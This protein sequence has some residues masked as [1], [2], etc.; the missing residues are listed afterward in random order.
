MT[1]EVFTEIP[2]PAGRQRNLHIQWLRAAAAIMVVLFHASVY[3]VI[4]LKDNTFLNVLDGRLG[5]A[6]VS[7]FFAI[8]GYLMATA[9]K[10]Q[11]PVIFLAH[12]VVRIYP[13]FFIVAALY[14]LVEYILHQPV[15]LN[16]AAL[17]LAPVG[18]TA[19]YPLRVE[20][21]LV[22]EVT[23]YVTLFLVALCGQ[24]RRLPLVALA[25]L[26]LLAGFSILRPDQG[27]LTYPVQRILTVCENVGMAGGLLIPSLLRFRLPPWL[28]LAVGLA[29][30]PI[31]TVYTP[32]ID[33]TR[34][35]FGIGATLVVAGTIGLSVRWPDFGRNRAGVAMAA[36]GDYSYAL[37]LVHVPVIYS[38]Y[39]S[40]HGVSYP[41]LW[42]M[43]LV[44]TLACAIVLGRLDM[45]LYRRLKAL[46]N[47]ARQGHLRIAAGL[48]LVFMLAMAVPA[49][50]KLHVVARR[51]DA[52]RALAAQIAGH[53]PLATIGQI[54]QAALAAGFSES[55]ALQGAI[56]RAGISD[57]AF[58]VA[59]WAVDTRTSKGV[60]SVALFQNG[61]LLDA[62]AT[63]FSPG[64]IRQRFGT[65]A[66]TG[67]AMKPQGG[68]VPTGA[69][70]GL[71]LG[72]DRSFAV[73]SGQPVP[74]CTPR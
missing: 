50:W 10:V 37:Y 74:D 59:G 25:W 54:R 63:W 32:G 3:G 43:A 34:W 14:C 65:R 73:L 36:L 49:G 35:L 16:L 56:D 57:D 53:G 22:F 15:R 70:T 4:L 8:S 39:S 72:P 1:G 23:F 21:T 17:S 71:A 33:A 19:K 64:D 44:L 42:G 18:N 28:L 11:Q 12:R 29:A 69:V 48:F 30:W 60:M 13:I 9:I 27:E 67:F 5:A 41:V 2:H 45:G 46:V 40:V 52:A 58:Q 6:G 26:A 68:C 55:P 38:L 66:K 31:Y 62:G 20:W 7:L 61:R 47:N 51:E 24:A